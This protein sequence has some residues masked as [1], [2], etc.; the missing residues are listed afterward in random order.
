MRAEVE[1][2]QKSLMVTEQPD[3][4]EEFFVRQ[5]SSENSDKKLQQALEFSKCLASALAEF[6]KELTGW[7]PQFPVLKPLIL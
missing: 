4:N 3:A 7:H 5:G 1:A 2:N 6:Q